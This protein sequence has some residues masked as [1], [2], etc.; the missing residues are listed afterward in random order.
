MRIDQQKMS[1]N[2]SKVVLGVPKKQ[3]KR[4]GKNRRNKTDHCPFACQ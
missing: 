1:L 3:K 2:R 4:T